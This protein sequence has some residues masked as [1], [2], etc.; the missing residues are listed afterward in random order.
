M[1]LKEKV[2]YQVAQDAIKLA[3][4]LEDV[5][6]YGDTRQYMVCSLLAKLVKQDMDEDVLKTSKEIVKDIEQKLL[7]IRED[8]DEKD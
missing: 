2:E 7:D 1:S 8:I 5:L 3:T 6:E 4:I